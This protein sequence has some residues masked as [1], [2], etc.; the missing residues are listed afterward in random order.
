MGATPVGSILINLVDG[1]RQPLPANVQWSARIFD[2]RVPSEWHQSEINGTGSALLIKGLTYFDNLFDNYTV[3]VSA[4]G[5]QGAAW[6]PV[7][8]SPAKPATLD[9]MLIHEGSRL[10]FSGA[11]WQTLNSTRPRFA[12]I[13]S[14][15]ITDADTR[16]ANL[17]DQ[18]KGMVLACL[19]NLFTAM[20]KITLA[21]GKS[22]LDYH[23]QPIWGDAQ[24]PM[25]QD[26][27]F[28]YVEQALIGDVMKAA[29]MG[30]F[31]EEKDPDISRPSATLSYKQT[32]FDVT[33]V[34][35]TFH[36]R[37]TKT[38]RGADGSPVDCVIVQPEIDLYKDLLAHFFMDVVPNKFTKGLTDPRA[39]YVLR[40][41]AGKQAGSD[42]NPLYTMTT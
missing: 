10:N 8:I 41:M 20:S 4:K 2:G 17:M 13:I 16:Y 34:Q 6:K 22:P 7:N 36:E 33:N 32:Q 23:W 37:N 14:A 24:F 26:R 31:V 27:F 29:A 12:Q 38:L 15:G 40:W 19:L 28:A 11:S 42:F 1:T 18:S 21:S 3:I 9:L 5:Y 30:A 35:L 39:V 25:A